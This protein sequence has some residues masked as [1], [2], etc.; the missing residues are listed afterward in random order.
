MPQSTTARRMCWF[1][2]D[3]RTDDHPA[4]AFAAGQL[5]QTSTEGTAD[6][7]PNAH[8]E[9]LC[10]YVEDSTVR[11]RP[12]RRRALY[13]ALLQLQ[14]NLDGN[15]LIVRG[16]PNDLIPELVRRFTIDEVAVSAEYYY[17]GLQRDKYI[18]S[19]VPMHAHGDNYAQSPGQIL[20]QSGTQYKVFTPFYNSWIELDC[21][22]PYLSVDTSAG[23]FQPI[24]TEVLDAEPLEHGVVVT[25]KELAD[26]ASWQPDL[27]GQERAWS[28][29]CR[30]AKKMWLDYIS[31]T[32]PTHSLRD[33]KAHRDTPALDGTS[34]ISSQLALG[35]IH[36]RTLLWDLRGPQAKVDTDIADEDIAAF[37]R[38]LA[39]REFYA[40]YLY[41]RPE[42]GW[43]DVN[44]KFASFVWNEL[45]EGWRDNPT[46]DYLA[47]I[48]GRTGF[49]LIDAGMRQLAA[50]GWMHNRVRMLVA[51]FLTK[52]LHL[53]WQYGA[54]YF[55]DLLVDG[56]FATNQHSW[57]W[58]AGTGTDASPYFRV[59]NPDTQLKKFDPHET[60]VRRWISEY[61]TGDYPAPIVD[62]AAERLDALARY[63]AIK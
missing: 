59:F 29:G 5:D 38:Q 56:D 9:T 10:V 49:P 17:S 24:S 13:Q 12:I 2:T 28:I 18:A 3:L 23:V 30:S 22:P 55:L 57:Q 16:A 37:I 35:C 63:E 6:T 33:Y 53:R 15:L 58:A 26:G 45:P 8:T 27:P 20:T 60:Y 47:W 54:A 32:D 44:P 4:L 48:E 43:S 14:E 61:G 39:F 1:R 42:T 62:H 11:L 46:G 50:T 52:D 51:S 34:R 41:H 7:A 25:D 36:P 31:D 40:D 19:Q 21:K